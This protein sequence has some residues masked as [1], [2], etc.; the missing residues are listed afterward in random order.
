MKEAAPNRISRK[1]QPGRPKALKR[2]NS[3]YR[4]GSTMASR[5]TRGRVA[6]LEEMA[7]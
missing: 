4:Y 2:L 3:G 7:R 1:E 6:K 5:R